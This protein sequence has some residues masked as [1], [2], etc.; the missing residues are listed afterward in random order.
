VV[1]F[2]VTQAPNNPPQWT[3]SQGDAASARAQFTKQGIPRA[4]VTTDEYD[5]PTDKKGLLKWLNDHAVRPV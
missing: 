1:K 5:V 3:A 2:Y 4:Q